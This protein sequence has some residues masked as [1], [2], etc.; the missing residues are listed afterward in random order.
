MPTLPTLPKEISSILFV[1][2]ISL[3]GDRDLP[4]VFAKRSLSM[5]TYQQWELGH[6]EGGVYSSITGLSCS[7]LYSELSRTKTTPALGLWVAGRL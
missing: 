6:R 2:G 7:S 4:R 5:L 1:V 3:V